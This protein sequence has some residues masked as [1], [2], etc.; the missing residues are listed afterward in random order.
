[1]SLPTAALL[2]AC[3][4]R[5][6]AVNPAATRRSIAPTT[7]LEEMQA[8]GG[9]EHS[10]VIKER[11]KAEKAGAAAPRAVPA[12]AESA[13]AP[14]AEAAPAAEQ[15][16]PAPAVDEDAAKAERLRKREEALARKRAR[17]TEG[18]Q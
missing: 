9:W 8:R 2:H 3:L 17:E 14:G 10:D 15:P 11:K 12:K 7:A 4:Q 16:A 13:A 1:M 6:P 5:M 18:K